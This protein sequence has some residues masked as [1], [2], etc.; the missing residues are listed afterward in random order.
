MII[1]FRTY[2]NVLS[3]NSETIIYITHSNF[4][5]DISTFKRKK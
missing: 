3:S 5:L 1:T 2:Y 4:Y